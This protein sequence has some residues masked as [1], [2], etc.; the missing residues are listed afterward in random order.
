LVNFHLLVLPA[1]A[2]MQGRGAIYPDVIPALNQQQFS[3]KPGRDMALLGRLERG[4]FTVTRGGQYGSGMLLPLAESNALALFESTIGEI[5]EGASIR[6]LSLGGE[7]VKD[8]FD[9]MNRT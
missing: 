9:P 5:G 6:V 8:W 4:L 1:L 2:K 7:P 3:V